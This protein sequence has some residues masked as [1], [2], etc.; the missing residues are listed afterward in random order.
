M[1]FGLTVAAYLAYAW[2]LAPLLEPGLTRPLH[3]AKHHRPIPA[4][5]DRAA[6]RQANL[7]WFAAGDWEL[8]PN[9]KMLETPDGVL[10]FRQYQNKPD[11]TVQIQPCTMIFF[12]RGTNVT[13]EQRTD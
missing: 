6:I 12:P 7:P 4:R 1:A 13:E 3:T 8:D 11:G 5:T 10:L 2:T 9:N